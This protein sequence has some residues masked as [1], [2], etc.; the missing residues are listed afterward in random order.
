MTDSAPPQLISYIAPAAPATRRPAEGRLPFLRPEIGF[1]PAWYRQALD[2]DFGK[3]W[4][5]DLTYRRH[6]VIAMRAEL[7][8]RFPDSPIARLDQSG[9]TLDL[10]TGVCGASVVAAIYGL[11][12]VYAA[13]KWPN[14][15]PD[16]LSIA[17]IDQLEPPDLDQNPF[18]QALLQQ[19]ASI[20]RLEG[21][22][23]GFLNWQGI[24][25][26]AQRLRGPEIL[27]DLIDAPQR[28]QRLFTCIGATM[29]D[30]LR[31]LQALQAT[32]GVSY[33]FITISNCLVN[34]ISP[35]QY[36]KQ[37]LP[38][39][40]R[41]AAAFETIG[42]HN[43]AW[44]ATPYLKVYSLI[45]RIAYLDLGINSDLDQARA[46]YPLTRRAVMYTPMDLSQKSMAEIRRDLLHIANTYGPCDVVCADIDAGA[47]DER[48]R[49]VISECETIS[50]R[51][52]H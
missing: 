16:Y 33:R 28:C 1:T 26:N 31:R 50:Q 18:F 51:F 41:L 52:Q 10:L 15:A 46:L 47:R 12:I 34:L 11:P 37:I 44:N 43:C 27:L 22:V 24:L 29:I 2:I 48:I 13:D 40:Q 8:R 23:V 36:Q 5:L 4:H 20:A 19:V 38:H 35:G 3:R 21:K 9:Q 30:G 49:E 45:P 14:V 32:S 25:N 7:R 39:D 17:E 6:S 42:I